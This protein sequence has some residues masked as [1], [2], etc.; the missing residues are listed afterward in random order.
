MPVVIPPHRREKSLV[1][2]LVE[3]V[4][5]HSG[6]IGKADTLQLVFRCPFAKGMVDGT[7]LPISQPYRRTLRER[8]LQWRKD[9]IGSK[10][11]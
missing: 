1:P 10:E 3:Q 4:G 2:L 7:T 9:N 5:S 8:L 11:L 6:M